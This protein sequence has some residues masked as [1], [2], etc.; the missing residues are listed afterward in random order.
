M[1]QQVQGLIIRKLHMNVRW[2]M[3]YMHLENNQVRQN[4]QHNVFLFVVAHVTFAVKYATLM[5]RTLIGLSGRSQGLA[6]G[7][8]LNASMYTTVADVICEDAWFGQPMYGD[9]LVAHGRSRE[10]TGAS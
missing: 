6:S 10:R 7:G 4:L 2:M 9:T 1:G 8:S 5:S 3:N